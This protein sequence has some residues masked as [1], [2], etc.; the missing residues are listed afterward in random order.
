MKNVEA[1]F[2]ESHRQDDRPAPLKRR[3]DFYKKNTLR[4]VKFLQDQGKLSEV[5]RRYTGKVRQEVGVVYSLFVNIGDT[6]N[7]FI[8][9]SLV[10][11]CLFIS[12]EY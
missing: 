7:S 1:R 8:F 9:L 5:S 6:V 2:E 11:N 4:L 10:S 12:C 3:I